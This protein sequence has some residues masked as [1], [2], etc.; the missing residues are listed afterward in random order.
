M[1]TRIQVE[2]GSTEMITGID[3]VQ[4]QIRIAAGERLRLKQRDI[5]FRGHSIECRINAEDPYNFLPSPGR[6]TQWHTPGGPGL[7]L[8]LRVFVVFTVSRVIDS[9]STNFILYVK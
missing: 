5:L 8:D 7:C 2:H 6:I 4:E 3:L 9:L 1:H